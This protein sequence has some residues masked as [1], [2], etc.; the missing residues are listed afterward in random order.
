LHFPDRTGTLTSNQ[1]KKIFND[2]SQKVTGDTLI[3][4][5][6]DVYSKRG[7]RILGR[8]AF[9]AKAGNAHLILLKHFPHLTDMFFLITCIRNE[10]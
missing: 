5:A 9:L 2:V 4:P 8:W 7:L 6:T 1:F 3:A 10:N